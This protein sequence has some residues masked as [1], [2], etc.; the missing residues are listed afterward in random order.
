MIAMLSIIAYMAGQDVGLQN[1]YASVGMFNNRNDFANA[2]ALIVPLAF[3]FLLRG[4]LSLKMVMVLVIGLA[5]YKIFRSNSRGGQMAALLGVATILYLTAKTRGGK[6]AM[7]TVGAVM[8]ALALTLS[9]HLGTIVKYKEDKSAMGR[10]V[11]WDD[12]MKMFRH[13][14]LFGV[15]YYRFGVFGERDSHSTFMRALGELGGAGLFV[16][17]GLCFVAFRDAYRLSR[18]AP[19]AE[20]QLLAYGMT[21]MLAAYVVGS[22]FMTGLYQNYVHIQFAFV[23]ALR[24]VADRERIQLA[25]GGSAEPS[26]APDEPKPGRA[27]SLGLLEP[28]P[29]VPTPWPASWG[30]GLAARGLMERGDWAKIFGLTVLCWFTYKLFIIRSF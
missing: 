12:A 22:L 23:A 2:M 28:P 1:Q 20:I 11:A 9:G 16:I 19:S 4:R 27:M 30:P 13:H 24:L 21:G 25:S 15:G 26:D 29:P 3:V 10:V 17:V 14:P 5:M 6:V 7:I 8:L 18:H